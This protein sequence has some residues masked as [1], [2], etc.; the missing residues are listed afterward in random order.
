MS[1]V[2]PNTDA[3]KT[4]RPV[5]WRACACVAVLT[6]ALSGE[7][8]SRTPF[9]DVPWLES[10]HAG[11]MTVLRSPET[12]WEIVACLMVYF[13]GFQWLRAT[14]QRDPDWR[15]PRS[16]LLNAF[17]ALAT[18]AYIRAYPDSAG[19][20]DCLTLVTAI[21]MAQGLAL[22]IAWDRRGNHPHLSGRV[23]LRVFALVIAMLAFVHPNT[24]MTFEYRELVRWS[25][26]WRTPNLYGVLMASAAVISLVCALEATRNARRW[27]A[28]GWLAAL[29]VTSVGLVG[30]LSRGAWLG[31][32][33][34]LG[35]IALRWT[36]TFAGR[37]PS[38]IFTRATVARLAV[39]VISAYVIGYWT[40]RF[41]ERPL[42][43]RA[44]TVFN[45]ND[46]S[47]RN[48]VAT[49]PG[50]LQMIAER[51]FLG[52]GWNRSERIYTSLYK[53]D[54]MTEGA[55]VTQNDFLM[56]G[57]T[58]GAPAL[59]CFLIL[60]T[61]ALR[62]AM[63]RGAGLPTCRSEEPPGSRPSG[64]EDTA[65]SDVGDIGTGRSETHPRMEPTRLAASAAVIPLLVGFVFDGLLLKL[66][67]AVPFFCLMEI[68]AHPRAKPE[69]SD[70][71][72]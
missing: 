46:F 15:R 60:I 33:L 31:A 69:S 34:A 58:L 12:Q 1:T 7:W 21:V 11:L 9:T 8:L 20:Q 27:V 42:V 65:D 66:A 45:A 32:A 29:I 24:G 55:A 10:L 25:G 43:R 37:A 59:L 41:S 51:P 6:L 48:R 63:L 62:G 23:F 19:G 30:S 61:L 70:D 28:A 44:F 64:S 22:W 36:P 39:I 53:P 57:M 49:I 68:V 35:W 47:W 3:P 38:W 26:I 54:F 5:L 18:V 2:Q 16:L 4:F 13:I 67:T 40:L 52:H 50:S 17:V 56:L 14:I 72:R 71:T